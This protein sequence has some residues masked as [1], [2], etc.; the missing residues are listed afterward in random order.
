VTGLWRHFKSI[1]ELHLADIV[2]DEAKN[3]ENK[4]NVSCVPP[5]NQRSFALFFFIFAM[6]VNHLGSLV[7]HPDE[8]LKFLIKANISR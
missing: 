5:R 2:L 7:R 4:E 3:K 8:S 1:W 6:I